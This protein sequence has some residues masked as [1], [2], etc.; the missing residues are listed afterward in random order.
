MWVWQFKI[1][2]KTAGE[3]RC[4]LGLQ[5]FLASDAVWDK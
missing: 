1:H 2:H 3:L 4:V 5:R